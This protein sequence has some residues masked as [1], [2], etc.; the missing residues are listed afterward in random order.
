MQPYVVTKSRAALHQQATHR[1]G[2]PGCQLT[3]PSRG[4]AITE[5]RRTGLGLRIPAYRGKKV[6]IGGSGGQWYETGTWAR[7]GMARMCNKDQPASDRSAWQG[8][9]GHVDGRVAGAGC[10]RAAKVGRRQC[11]QIVQRQMWSLVG[12]VAGCHWLALGT[13]D[14]WL[15]AR[16]GSIAHKKR[17]KERQS[18][19]RARVIAALAG[20]NALVKSGWLD[21][22]M[23][24]WA[25]WLSAATGLCG[26]LRMMLHAVRRVWDLG[27]PLC[28][29]SQAAA[30]WL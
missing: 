7:R 17:L 30:S 27:W 26:L 10:L 28:A 3:V 29:M 25:L 6:V 12:W 8:G 5:P 9:V 13:A 23:E 2:C 1:T 14:C 18:S 24:G 16:K 22:W 11:G 15:A 20:C 21:G 19:R 4:T